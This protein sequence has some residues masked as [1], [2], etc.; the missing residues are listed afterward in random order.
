MLKVDIIQTGAYAVNTYLLTDTLS[1]E[2]A[3]ID[4]GE[5]DPA[6]G[7]FLRKNDVRE[8]KYILLTHG[9]FDH[10]CGVV[11]LKKMY[12][13]DILIHGE[14]AL[15]LESADHSLCS[16]VAD[17]TQTETDDY[18]TFS[19][20]DEIFLG[21]T[22]ITVKHTPGHT[23][24][25]VIFMTEDKIFSGDTLFRMSMGRT[26]LPGGSTKTLFRS[27]REIGQI[28]GEYDIFPGHGEE[29]TLS[30][31]KRNN[32]YLRANGNFGN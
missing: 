23:R 10:I 14:D 5:Y 6:F 17:Y 32:R 30:Y 22:K 4:I 15:C 29:T 21:E 12:G 7:A 24:G 25:S 19:D 13:G 8:L 27:L 20:G 3:V 28:E 18:K 26:D 16:A 31:E 11:P 9:H 2:S 1:G